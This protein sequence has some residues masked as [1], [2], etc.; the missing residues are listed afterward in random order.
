MQ[1]HF[2]RQAKSPYAYH[3]VSYI[4]LIFYNFTSLLSPLMLNFSYIF[5]FF[6]WVQFHIFYLSCV[7]SRIGTVFHLIFEI[8]LLMALI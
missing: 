7:K 6:F 2:E 1:K 5:F 4:F 8:D 3:A